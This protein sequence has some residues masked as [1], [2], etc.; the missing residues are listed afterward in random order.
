MGLRAVPL[1]QDAGSAGIITLALGVPPNIIGA[2]G[3]RLIVAYAQG[4]V[5]SLPLPPRP[6]SPVTTL[7]SSQP[8]PIDLAPCGSNACWLAGSNTIEELNPLGGPPMA[9]VTLTGA[10]AGAFDIAFDDTNAYVIGV[11]ATGTTEALERVPLDGSCPVVLVRMP[12]G[13]EGGVTVDDECVYW[14]NSEGIFSLAATSEGG[15]Q[16]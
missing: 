15:L 7:G 1:V 10:V 8:G 9:V 11:D 14:S 13:D 6:N 3:Q 2:F 4:A 5:E 16:Q 12:Y